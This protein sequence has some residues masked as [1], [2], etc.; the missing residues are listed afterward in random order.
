ML[1]SISRL[2]LG[3]LIGVGVAACGERQD[4]DSALEPDYASSV[5]A[6]LVECPSGDSFET[7]GDILGTGGTVALRGHSV[8]VPS[9]ALLGLTQ[10]GLAEPASKYVLIDLSANGQDHFQFLAPVTVTVSYARCSRSDI[11]RAPLSVWLVD[12]A[13]GE[14]LQ[15]MGG[16]D[17]KLTRTLTFQTDHFSGY[18]IAN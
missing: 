7:T 8:L 3:L 17:N 15:N 6:T 9:G 16:I 1:K 2:G 11:L 18:A 14:L 13:T 4:G 10:I 5:G 12:P